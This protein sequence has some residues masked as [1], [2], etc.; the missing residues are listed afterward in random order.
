MGNRSRAAV[1]RNLPRTPL[2]TSIKTPFL[3]CKGRLSVPRKSG[4]SLTG[5]ARERE[6]STITP[7]ETTIM[8][9]PEAISFFVMATLNLSRAGKIMCSVMNWLRTKGEAALEYGS[10]HNSFSL[11]VVGRTQMG[12]RG[13]TFAIDVD[14]V[15]AGFDELRRCFGRV[16]HI[17]H[18]DRGADGMAVG[19]GSGVARRFAI[20]GDQFTSP[21]HRFGVFQ[22]EDRQTPFHARGF[23][24]QQRLTAEEGFVPVDREGETRF[25]RRVVRGKFRAPGAITLFQAQ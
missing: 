16:V 4:S 21:E 19:T 24:F 13:I 3:V 11:R 25:E 9:R 20:A 6:R 2:A 10:T 12:R 18:R 22:D 17:P 1:L 8:A 14:F 23:L 15:S 5:T 7:I